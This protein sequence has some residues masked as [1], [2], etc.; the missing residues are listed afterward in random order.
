MKK[1]DMVRSLKKFPKVNQKM[2]AFSLER[3]LNRQY[4]EAQDLYISSDAKHHESFLSRILAGYA[5]NC[6][7]EI[8]IVDF[9]GG[10]AFEY[11]KLNSCHFPLNK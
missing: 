2:Q 4:Q 8:K 1:K 5:G 11:L 7:S 6:S 10:L 3:W 9:G